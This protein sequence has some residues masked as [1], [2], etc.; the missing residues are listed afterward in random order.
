MRFLAPLY[1]ML[2]IVAGMQVGFALALTLAPI[3][4]FTGRIALYGLWNRCVSAPPLSTAPG[5]LASAWAND[6]TGLLFGVGLGVTFL[7]I[8]AWRTIPSLEAGLGLGVAWVVVEL[9]LA[10]R[11]VV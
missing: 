7:S 11:N 10:R 2:T 1:L 8:G 9:V 5:E 6:F 4:A 3:A